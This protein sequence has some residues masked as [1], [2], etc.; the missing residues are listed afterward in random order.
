MFFL[1]IVL[2]GEKTMQPDGPLDGRSICG[3]SADPVPDVGEAGP[4]SRSCDDAAGTGIG[5]IEGKCT[6]VCS[7]E[8]FVACLVFDWC[9]GYHHPPAHSI[10]TSIGTMI[11]KMTRYGY[12]GCWYAWHRKLLK[13]PVGNL[14]MVMCFDLLLE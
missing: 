10:V 1:L 14:Y 11:L 5:C 8:F 6:L 3:Y 4:C 2:H 13:K 9:C 7:G 12:A